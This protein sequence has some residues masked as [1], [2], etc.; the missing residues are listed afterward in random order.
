M[1]GP[2]ARKLGAATLERLREAARHHGTTPFALA[3]HAALAAIR[4]V[5]GPGELLVGTTVDRRSELAVA[6]VFGPAFNYVPVRVSLDQPSPEDVSARLEEAL[7]GRHLPLAD[8]IEPAADGPALGLAVNVNYYELGRLGPEIA[9]LRAGA[10]LT[11]GPTRANEMERAVRELPLGHLPVLR[12]YA[13]VIGFHAATQG[14][15]FSLRHADGLMTQAEAEAA[16]DAVEQTLCANI[17]ARGRARA[18]DE[19]P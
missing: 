4:R 3:F 7:A 19:T 10:E 15:S 13:L 14:L 16:C 18:P 1:R 6:D 9:A 2:A 5:A 8:V 12:P 17:E 11:Q